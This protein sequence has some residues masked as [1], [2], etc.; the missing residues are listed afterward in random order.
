V[1]FKLIAQSLD[2]F[3]DPEGD[4]YIQVQVEGNSKQEVIPVDS[5]HG[6]AVLRA[7]LCD[8]LKKGFP[9]DH[10]TRVAVD[11]IKGYAFERKRRQATAAA[12]YLI[13]QKPLAQAVLAVAS[14]GGTTKNVPRLLATLTNHALRNAIDTRSVS[15]PRNEDSLGRQLSLLAPLL[16]RKGV[17][18]TR[19][20]NNERT[21]TIS[22]LV[23]KSVEG[24]EEVS[25]TTAD[26][27]S[28]SNVPV[29]SAPASSCSEN[30]NGDFDPNDMLL[31]LCE[32]E[33]T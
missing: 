7:R 24:D 21:W 29:T 3:A 2:P 17:K 5:P 23:E 30:N 19:Q 31:K 15:W 18:L 27:G 11:V 16:S 9:T 8:V 22:P 26:T 13:A 33:T 6:M 4:T 10:E 28:G 25:V 1:S 20:R 12:D 14:S 32:G